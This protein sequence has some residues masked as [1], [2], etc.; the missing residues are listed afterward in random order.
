MAQ[1]IKIKR[2]YDDNAKEDGYRVLIDR[3]WPRG[4]KK[5]DAHIDQWLKDFSP[6]SDLRKWFNHQPERFDRF[7][8]LYR[9]ELDSKKQPIQE[10]LKNHK[11]KKITLLYG[12]KDETHNHAI[13]LQDYL[14]KIK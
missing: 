10:F 7:K 3:L 13:V 1:Q 2:I 5:E 12:A 11:D 8:A 14:K 6:S 9:E 4:V